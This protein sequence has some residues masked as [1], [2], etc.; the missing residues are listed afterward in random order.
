MSSSPLRS[1]ASNGPPAGRDV[2]LLRAMRSR[3][4]QRDPGAFNNLGVLYHTR[5]LHAE[6]VEAFRTRPLDASPYTFVAAD[7]LVLKV[8]EN[9]RVVGVRNTSVASTSCASSRTCR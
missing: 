1:P 5:G 3:I 6:A 8:R 7:A 2:E 4:D 9:S